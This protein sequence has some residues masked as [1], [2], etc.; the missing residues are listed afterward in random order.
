VGSRC[1]VCC[2]G[3]CVVL[4]WVWGGFGVCVVIACFVGS[5]TL[6]GIE[7]YGVMPAG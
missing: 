3:Y 6:R 4:V 2:Y 1:G 5:V 7:R